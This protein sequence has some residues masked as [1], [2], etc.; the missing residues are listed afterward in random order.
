MESLSSDGSV[1]ASE[2]DLLLIALKMANAVQSKPSIPTVPAV[3]H[4]DH[5]YYHFC[6]SISMQML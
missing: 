2:Y 6:I 5:V 3:I 1:Q 4:G